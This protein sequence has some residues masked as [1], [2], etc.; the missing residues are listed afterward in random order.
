MIETFSVTHIAILLGVGA[1]LVG[2]IYSF[3][4]VLIHPTLNGVSKATWCV[5]IV[6]APFAWVVWVIRRLC[7]TR[8]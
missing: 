8:H 3:V 6:V 1:Y 4:E 5:G 2:A 7:A